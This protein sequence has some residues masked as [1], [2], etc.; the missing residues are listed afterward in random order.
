[1]NRDRGDPQHVGDPPTKYDNAI[2]KAI[3]VTVGLEEGLM[4]LGVDDIVYGH[5]G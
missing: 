2:H 1:M 4:G 5:W 3:P